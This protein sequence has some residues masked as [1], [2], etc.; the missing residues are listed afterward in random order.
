M[1]QF[2]SHL[3][4]YRNLSDAGAAHHHMTHQAFKIESEALESMAQVVPDD[5]DNLIEEQNQWMEV[6]QSRIVRIRASVV[7]QAHVLPTGVLEVE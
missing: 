4:K 3:D 2:R 6:F 5:R 1:S 7:D